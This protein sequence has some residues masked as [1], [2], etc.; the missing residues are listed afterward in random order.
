MTLTDNELHAFI[1][2]SGKTNFTQTN[3]D[4][5]WR[6]T[7]GSCLTSASTEQGLYLIQPDLHFHNSQCGALIKFALLR[8]L[9]YPKLAAERFILQSRL[10]PAAINQ[11][12]S[13]RVSLA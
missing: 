7:F 4:L 6:H 12:I 10:V 1:I 9:D 8:W 3:T 13:S 5:Y 11:L 2:E